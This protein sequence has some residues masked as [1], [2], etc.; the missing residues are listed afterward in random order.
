M[1][2]TIAQY[3]VLDTYTKDDLIKAADYLAMRE[4]M[5]KRTRLI[6]WLP[7]TADDIRAGLTKAKSLLTNKY[8]HNGI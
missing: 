6:A 4:R 1:N 7:E 3:P 8:K 2:K 5:A